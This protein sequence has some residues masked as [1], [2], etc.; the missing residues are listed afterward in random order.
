MVAQAFLQLVSDVWVAPHASV[1]P[2]T[3]RLA[4]ALCGTVWG[5][6]S[7]VVQ[8][9]K[10]MWTCPPPPQWLCPPREGTH[11]GRSRSD[12][13][14]MLEGQLCCDPW[15]SVAAMPT[16]SS[17]LGAGR[18]AVFLQA[19]HRR[20]WWG[21]FRLAVSEGLIWDFALAH[22][23]T[24]AQHNTCHSTAQHGL[25]G[26]PFSGTDCRLASGPCG[27]PLGWWSAVGLLC[28]RKGCNREHADWHTGPQDRLGPCCF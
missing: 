18:V 9:L 15:R 12:S 13:G 25:S 19:W 23:H 10:Y 7:T 6:V 16:S 4:H 26:P 17:W 24:P 11:I 14:A 20:Q 27:Q 2:L 3:D 21:V 5:G 28:M 8:L 22:R 1:R